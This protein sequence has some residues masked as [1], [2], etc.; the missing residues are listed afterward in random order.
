MFA[1]AFESLEEVVMVHEV[2]SMRSLPDTVCG[3][4]KDVLA[5]ISFW[6][7]EHQATSNLKKKLH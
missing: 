7:N 5:M 6:K 2:M 1:R 3:C 4:A